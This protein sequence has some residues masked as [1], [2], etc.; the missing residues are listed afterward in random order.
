MSGEPLCGIEFTL[1]ARYKHHSGGFTKSIPCSGITPARELRAAI[2]RP[3]GTPYPHFEASRIYTVNDIFNIISQSKTCHEI[4]Y[5]NWED[6]IT[7]FEIND[8]I[9]PNSILITSKVQIG[10]IKG[11]IILV[12]QR[13]KFDVPEVNIK[14]YINGEIRHDAAFTST[15]RLCTLGKYGMYEFPNDFLISPKQ[16]IAFVLFGEIFINVGYNE[17]IHVARRYGIVIPE[18]GR[19]KLLDKCQLVLT[20]PDGKSMYAEPEIEKSFKFYLA[21]NP[22]IILNM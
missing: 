17:F 1:I 9:I 14:V 18:V 7:H 20:G 16:F 15:T 19:F 11:P 8:V 6:Y 21:L 22:R 12:A 13:K 5:G 10:E 4:F 3:G 2:N